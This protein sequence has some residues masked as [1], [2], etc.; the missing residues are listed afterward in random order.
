MLVPHSDMIETSLEH[1][2]YLPIYVHTTTKQNLNYVP[3]AVP[4]Q[5]RNSSCV[6]E[7]VT[8]VERYH[9]L[10]RYCFPEFPV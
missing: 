10:Y 6:L 3:K 4:G 5:Y 1:W 2:Q 8:R 9:K 7:A